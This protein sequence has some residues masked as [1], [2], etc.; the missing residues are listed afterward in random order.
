MGGEIK[1]SNG[2]TILSGKKDGENSRI[3]ALRLAAPGMQL[4]QLRTI[5]QQAPKMSYNMRSAAAQV[6]EEPK[7]AARGG[8]LAGQTAA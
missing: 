8:Y 1:N 7:M 5:N 6:L 3:A 4:Q 2:D